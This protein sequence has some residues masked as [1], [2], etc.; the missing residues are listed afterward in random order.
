MIRTTSSIAAMLAVA[1]LTGACNQTAQA[2]AAPPSYASAPTGVTPASFTLPEGAGCTA[3]IA[4]FQAI[5]DN[6]LKTGH[7]TLG[8]HDQISAELKTAA[9]ACSSGRDG[10]ASR[11]VRTTRGKFGYPTT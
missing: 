3:D 5:V 8:V 9:G 6:D 10:E 7:T 11:M 4:R 1:L 2:P